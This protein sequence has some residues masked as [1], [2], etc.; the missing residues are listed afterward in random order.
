MKTTNTA[1]K[2]EI[3][4]DTQ[5]P[6]NPGWAFRAEFTGSLEESGGLDA[7]EG[8][9]TLSREEAIQLAFEAAC[10][11]ELAEDCTIR[12]YWHGEQDPL[13]LSPSDV[14]VP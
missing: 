9:E 13:A 2:I 8:E 10:P 3:Y 1:T 11:F 7:F 12:V 4:R 14:A 6:S 5:D